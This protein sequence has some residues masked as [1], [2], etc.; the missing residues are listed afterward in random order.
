[1]IDIPIKYLKK[2][3]HKCSF[4]C[5]MDH[6]NRISTPT[7]T[8]S[9]W[10]RQQHP[11]RKTNPPNSWTKWIHHLDT[12]EG[13]GAASKRTEHQSELSRQQFAKAIDILNGTRTHFN[14]FTDG[15]ADRGK[16]PE[17]DKTEITGFGDI[18]TWKRSE[19]EGGY[20]DE[21]MRWV[22]IIGGCQGDVTHGEICAIE[23]YH[24]WIYDNL[25]ETLASKDKT[26]FTDSKNAYDHFIT[27]TPEK[28]KE[29]ERPFIDPK[30]NKFWRISGHIGITG[31]E[32]ADCNAYHGIDHSIRTYR[33]I[34]YLSTWS[35]DA[36]NSEISKDLIRA[37]INGQST[38]RNKGLGHFLFSRLCSVL[39][40][41]MENTMKETLKSQ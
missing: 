17:N 28:M 29:K 6:P 34:G 7:T 22:H 25:D 13:C 5:T 30:K 37:F 18:I 32:I 15:S 33:T 35:T 9:N 3:I 11:T 1:M 27:A 16:M 40:G 21:D 12:G 19:D 10:P 23:A 8:D 39:I 31:N 41:V 4:V 20:G 38:N 2:L 26:Y 36:S 14:I 24:K